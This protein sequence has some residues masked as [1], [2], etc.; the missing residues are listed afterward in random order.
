MTFTFLQPTHV[1]LYLVF[2]LTSGFC[3]FFF[4]NDVYHDTKYIDK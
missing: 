1:R 3:E 2:V 4:N